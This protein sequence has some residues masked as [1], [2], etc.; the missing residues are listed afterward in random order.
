MG[1]RIRDQ[2]LDSREARQKLKPSGK[3]YWRLLDRGLHFGYRKGQS[4]GK[5]VFRLYKGNE[6]YVVETIGNADDGALDADGATIF[7]F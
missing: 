3:P 6:Q 5:W 7:D 1:R 2:R 4:G